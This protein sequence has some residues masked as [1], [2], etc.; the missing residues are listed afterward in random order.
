MTFTASIDCRARQVCR[1]AVPG[2]LEQARLQRQCRSSRT[3]QANRQKWHGGMVQEVSISVECTSSSCAS[4]AGPAGS[5][6]EAQPPSILRAR[7]SGPFDRDDP[8]PRK[9]DARPLRLCRL[10]NIPVLV[11][12]VVAF[13][14]WWT[15]F[16]GQ[17]I[18]ESKYSQVR[19]ASGSAVGVSWFGKLLRGVDSPSCDRSLRNLQASSCN[20]Q[21]SLASS[22]SSHSASSRSIASS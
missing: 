5:S 8:A 13:A 10:S 6:Q 21:S 11:T 20:S 3:G 16:I 17:I 18:Y 22:S 9:A 7:P 1:T 4:H 12:F 14:A 15:A 2:S 19:D